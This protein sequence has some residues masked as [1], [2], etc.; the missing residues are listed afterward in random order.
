VGSWNYYIEIKTDKSTLDRMALEYK[1]NQTYQEIFR[2][3]IFEGCCDGYHAGVEALIDNFLPT[4]YLIYHF[5]SCHASCDLCIRT[6]GIEQKYDFVKK[7]EFI[8]FMYD[9]WEEKID[10]VYAQLGVIVIKNKQ[11][12][13][14]RNR[15][16]KKYYVKIPE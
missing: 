9:A 15:L 6:N 1:Q 12:Y 16:Y 13:R 10:F 2:F 5:L 11:Y 3:E 8:K 4:N 14:T 7:S